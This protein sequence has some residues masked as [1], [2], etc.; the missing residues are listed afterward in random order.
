MKTQHLS[1]QNWQTKAESQQGPHWFPIEHS[2]SVK[3]LTNKKAIKT[4]A[5]IDGEWEQAVACSVDKN[6]TENESTCIF[7]FSC[8]DEVTWYKNEILEIALVRLSPNILN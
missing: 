2:S 6:D 3:R 4:L 8:W 5:S 1:L 7:Y